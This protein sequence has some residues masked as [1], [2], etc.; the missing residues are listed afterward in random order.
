MKQLFLF[1]VMAFIGLQARAAMIITNNSNCTIQ[2]RVLAHDANNPG[3]CALRSNLITIAAGDFEMFANVSSLNAV[4][5]WQG[6][7]VAVTTGGTAVWGWDAVEYFGVTNMT[8]G[9]PGSC[10]I[11][12]SASAE[13][14][15][16]ADV[17]AFM[18]VIGSNTVA[19]F[20]Q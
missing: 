10:A 20:V 9:L 19:D 15:C 6:G 12:V 16:G 8:I 2:V 1:V 17:S 4:P 5:G 7:T 13:D 3:V 18:Y 14:L 11:S